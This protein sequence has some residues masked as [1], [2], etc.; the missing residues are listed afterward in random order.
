MIHHHGNVAP[1]VANTANRLRSLSTVHLPSRYAGCPYL[2]F[3]LNT[4]NGRSLHGFS[5]V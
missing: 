1:T 3:I 5:P 4:L 2:K